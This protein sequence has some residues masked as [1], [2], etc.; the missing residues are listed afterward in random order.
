MIQASTGGAE[1][2]TY[3]MAAAASFLQTGMHT[4]AKA[5]GDMGKFEALRMV[6]H[7]AQASRSASLAQLADRMDEALRVGSV[8]GADPLA[9]VKGMIGD[10]IEKLMKEA[11]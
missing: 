8:S 9:K 2:Q 11:E 7:L 4:R 10:M 1:K 3:G 5:R 6:K